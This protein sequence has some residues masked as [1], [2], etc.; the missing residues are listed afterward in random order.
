MEK[1]FNLTVTKTGLELLVDLVRRSCANTRNKE[2]R[3]TLGILSDEL[4]ATLYM[5]MIKF[6]EKKLEEMKQKLGAS[7]KVQKR[8]HLRVVV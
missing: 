6:S 1:M 3:R 4:D 7:K 5:D 2:R 8:K